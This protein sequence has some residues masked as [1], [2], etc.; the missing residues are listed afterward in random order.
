MGDSDGFRLSPST[1]KS[2]QTIIGKPYVTVSPI[3]IANG[4]LKGINNGADFGPDTPGTTTCGINEAINS[5][6]Q[7]MNPVSG[8]IVPCGTIRLIH[9]GVFSISSPVV[10]W[11]DWYVSIEGGL[12][13]SLNDQQQYNVKPLSVTVSSSSSS[14]CFVM[15][16]IN[17]GSSSPV[18]TGGYI[19]QCRINW[20]ATSLITA[21]DTA[22]GVSNYVVGQ[23]SSLTTGYPDNPS[24]VELEDV[25]FYDASDTLGN[26]EG[27]AAFLLDCN[28]VETL[29]SLTR[30]CAQGGVYRT[31]LFALYGSTH[32]IIDTLDIECAYA[33][34]S[35]TPNTMCY[36]G[37]GGRSR[38][39]SIHLF[40]YPGN[41]TLITTYPVRAEP[42]NV[43]K[44]YA[45]IQQP[46]S[47]TVSVSLYQP[48]IIEG[49]YATNWNPFASSGTLATLNL[50]SGA[51]L[52]WGQDA[53][54]T[55]QVGGSFQKPQ[56]PGFGVSTPT[57]P[58][59]AT[60]VQNTNPFP[61]RIYLLTAGA[62]TAFTITDPA[63]NVQAITV[64]LAA[65]MEFTLDPGAQIQF[66][67]T[68]A[69]TWKWYGI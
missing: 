34:P 18:V 60:N 40:G 8:R 63:G 51:W 4:G 25:T 35:S 15:K 67:Y 52:L 29:I 17:V 43:G 41:S 9:N 50:N 47:G 2:W 10:C 68:T 45:E 19:R 62:G 27:N 46:A 56:V 69:P 14:G 33:P 24:T 7:V 6:P 38:I 20:I 30:V 32:T 37:I 36:L 44:L 61:V 22:N 54:K 48:M 64:A 55:G 31:N 21:A 13:S 1:P 23:F 42:V 5:L 3:G 12:P 16:S 58:A 57:F 28:G 53:V 11:T 49:Y 66:T 26:G 39:G 65:G 59:T